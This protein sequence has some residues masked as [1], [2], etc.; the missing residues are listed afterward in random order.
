MKYSQP[1]SIFW[2]M[3]LISLMLLMHGCAAKSPTA[4]MQQGPS[5]VINKIEPRDVDGKT[6]IAVEGVEPIQQYTSF[7]LTEPL[8]LVVDISDA[9]IKNF[10]DKISVNKGAILDIT[11]SQVDNIARL[12][13]ALSQPVDTKLYQAG[14]KLMIEIAKPSGVVKAEPEAVKPAPLIAEQAQPV[15]EKPAEENLLLRN[16]R[17]AQQRSLLRSR[18]LRVRA[19]SRWSFPQTARW[20]RALSW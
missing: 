5:V 7:Q 8:R 18:R 4:G 14:G 16:R 1:R 15:P 17:K 19:V 2:L 11:P 12:E 9:D 13:I 10:H 3:I 6:E 20:C